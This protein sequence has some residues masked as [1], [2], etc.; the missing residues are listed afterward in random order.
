MAIEKDFDKFF[1]G[2]IQAKESYLNECL[3]YFIDHPEI[4][5]NT[6]DI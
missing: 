2:L 5:L 3:V 1:N 6:I 4:N